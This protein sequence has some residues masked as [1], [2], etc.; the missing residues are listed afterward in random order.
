MSSKNQKNPRLFLIDGT[1]LAYRSFFAFIRNPLIN[2]KG[3]NT[4]GVYGFTHSLMRL[5]KLEKPEYLACVFDT[6]A[7]TFRH[8]AYPEYK[9][10]REKMPDELRDQ[11]PE[12][13]KIVE[14]FRIPILEK[15]GFEA[16]DV[17]GTLAKWAE[18]QDLDVYMVTGDKDFMQLVS[19]KIKMYILGKADQPEIISTFWD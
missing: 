5:L 1:A 4:S 12:I 15:D 2:S 18:S 6:K 13:R 16:D 9:A 17:I 11:F 7:P 8:K 3:I 19:S 10:T 14:A